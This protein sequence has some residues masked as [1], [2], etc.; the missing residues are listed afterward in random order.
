[1]VEVCWSE[2]IQHEVTQAFV[3]VGFVKVLVPYAFLQSEHMQFIRSLCTQEDITQGNLTQTFS[4]LSAELVMAGK[5]C[6]IAQ[7]TFQKCFE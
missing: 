4:H 3:L 5:L 2:G 7:L 6:L 1:M